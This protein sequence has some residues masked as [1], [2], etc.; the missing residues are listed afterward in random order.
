MQAGP[1]NQRLQAACICGTS[2]VRLEELS[3]RLVCSLGMALLICRVVGMPVILLD[4]ASQKAQPH[5]P[6]IQRIAKEAPRF[7]LDTQQQV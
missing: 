6:G 3:D 1:V 7:Q 4:T 5:R 2:H